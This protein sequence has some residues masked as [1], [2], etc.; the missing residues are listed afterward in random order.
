MLNRFYQW[1][2]IGGCVR[3]D[4]STLRKVAKHAKTFTQRHRTSI[5]GAIYHGLLRIRQRSAMVLGRQG[6]ISV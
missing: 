5:G 1:P 3:I 2:I 4:C 6:Q